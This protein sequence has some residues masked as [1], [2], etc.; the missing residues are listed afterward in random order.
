MRRLAILAALALCLTS[1]VSAKTLY[2]A[3]QLPAA[4]DTNPGTEAQPFKTI[5][6]A[7]KQ[8]APGDTVYVKDGVYRERVD[9]P[10]ED[11]KDPEKR[12]TLAAFP[13]SRPIIKGSDVVSGPWQQ[14]DPARPIYF[15]PRDL[16]TQM[17]FSDEQP[18]RQIG[19]RGNVKRSEKTDGFKWKRQWDGKD[20][21][22]LKP[23]CFYYDDTAKRLYVWLVDGTNPDQHVIEA[24]VRTRAVTLQGTWTLSGLT[25]KHIADG[26]WPDE[27]A[28]GV[29][30]NRCL[31]ENCHI[32]QNEFVGLIVSGEDCVIK[33]N[34]IAYNGLMGLT[35]NVGYRMLVEG[36]EFHHNAW[37]G[38][39]ECLTAGNKM[40]TW[41]DSAFLRN[42]WH[43]EPAA[44]LWLDI[45]DGN[46]LIAENRFDDCACGIYFEICRWAVIANNVIRR[47]G[48]G[49]WSYSPDVL[50]AHNIVDSCGE[51]I[52]ISG[53][54]RVCNYN[55]S[56]S[57]PGKYSLLALRNN[58]VINNILIDCAGSFVGI[59]EDTGFG[60]GN[61]SDHNVF[62]WT[63]P[64]AHPTGLHLNFMRGWDVVYGR[65]PEWR[66]ERHYDEHSMVADPTLVREMDAGN[67][68]IALPRN[69]LVPDVGFIDRTA[70]D[71]RLKPDSPV[72]GAGLR[73]PDVLNSPCRPCEGSKV[74]SRQFAATLLS[75]APDQ[76]AAKQ[77][78]ESAGAHYRLQPLPRFQRLADLDALPADDPGL[79]VRWQSSGVYPTFDAKAEPEQVDDWEWAV[80]PDNRLQ[81]PSFK[82]PM[83]K[84]GEP[85]ASPWISSG[86]ITSYIAIATANLF[87]ASTQPATARQKVGKIIPDCEY[88]LWGDMVVSSSSPKCSGEAQLYLAI[89]DTLTPLG[90]P[91]AMPASP[92]QA[93][94]WNTMFSRYHSG[95]AGE[96]QNVGKDLYVVLS[97]VVKG[98]ADASAKDPVLSA[99][100]DNVALL[101]GE[102]PQ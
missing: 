33:G 25:M 71:Y 19:L 76:K 92:G 20:L 97:A 89:G 78:Y 102:T 9:S 80:Y 55:Q 53:Y 61:F 51:G 50:I 23:G 62:A 48:R 90:T 73:L 69:Q 52:T 14:P 32:T 100:W 40:V 24:A 45:S 54:P 3:T 98:P 49:I 35:S 66:Y 87:P 81:D 63:L 27:Q 82:L 36:N 94:H 28:V 41:R 38:D 42:W 95:K 31:V 34:E 1:L 15:V 13:G 4:A 37:S 59:T 70:L 6:A 43:D 79:N 58:L 88:I 5:S 93:R 101:T 44:A 83:L 18:L 64:V 30:G 56:V 12:C 91:A 10:L 21:A 57:E 17:V 86:E 84:A 75:D 22:D 65:L 26:M 11:W 29:S 68:W 67:P 16:Y 7:M 96:D 47:C 74:I 99:R 85:K 77:V 39:V 46:I 8:I 72:R 2:V 60:A